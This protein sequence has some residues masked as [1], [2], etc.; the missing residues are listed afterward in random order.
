VRGI[1]KKLFR[2]NEEIARLR[3]EV[4]LAEGE[5][6]MHR[7]LADDADRD[8]AVYE[9]LERLESRAAG[10]DVTALERALDRSRRDLERAEAKRLELL[11]RLDADR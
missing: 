2:L 6:N 3:R 11:Q 10:K 4:E 8:A 7:H 9:G 5:L 1:E